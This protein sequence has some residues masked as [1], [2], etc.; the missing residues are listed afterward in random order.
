[1]TIGGLGAARQHES[2]RGNDGDPG[3]LH[4]HT[5]PSRAATND[6]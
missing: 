2:K 3:D 5:I 1:V 4:A 6:G